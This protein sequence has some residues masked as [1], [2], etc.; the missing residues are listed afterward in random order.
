MD[1]LAP[2]QQAELLLDPESGALESEIIVT[3]VF[4][5]FTGSADDDDDKLV[6]FFVVFSSISEQV[7]SFYPSLSKKNVESNYATVTNKISV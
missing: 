3:T 4:E 7:K 2:N 6:Q 5:S 1:T